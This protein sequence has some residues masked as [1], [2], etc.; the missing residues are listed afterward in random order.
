MNLHLEDDPASVEFVKHNGYYRVGNLNYNFKIN[1]L[2]AATRLNL[3]VQWEY[4]TKIYR[5]LDWK[6]TTGVSPTTLYRIRAEQLRNNYDY[7]A[8]CFSGGSDSYTVLQSFI[9][10]N[11]HLDEIICDWPLSQTGQLATS[12]NRRPENYNSEWALAIKPVLDYIQKYYPKIKI[13]VTDSLETLSDEDYED[14]CTLT[15]IHNYVSL[16]RYR[17]ILERTRSLT[18]KYNKVALILGI[19][20]PRILVDKNVCCAYFSDSSCWLKS[21]LD[22][23]YPRYVEYFYWTPDL[24]ELVVEQAQAVYQHL[25]QNK[26]L[27]PLLATDS[28]DLIKSLIYPNWDSAVFQAD[29]GTSFIYNEQYSWFFKK[30]KTIEIQSW[31]SSMTSR[32][33][34]VDHQYLNFFDDGRF[35]GY[36]ECYSRLYPIGIL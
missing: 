22:S 25:L 12:N 1:A 6:K 35:R 19:D 31:E 30:E 32:L 7:L 3:P 20:K 28:R 13:T 24:P 23:T 36:K 26:K 9:N 14:T 4:N 11:I 27:I 18:E 33:N 8:L 21:S 16:K 29:K 2:E 10:N 5:G 15:Q 34:L 17:K